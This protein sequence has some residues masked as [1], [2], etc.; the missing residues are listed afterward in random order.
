[1]G[2]SSLWRNIIVNVDS[3]KNAHWGMYPAGT[4]YVS[5]YI[6]SRGGA[7]PATLF[8]GLQAFLRE[9][10]TRPVTLDDIHEA[11]AVHG[12]MGVP[13]NRQNW[14]DLVN[15]H[16][17]RLPVEIEAVPEG[18]VVPT[19]N[20]LVQLVNTDPRYPWITNFIETALLRAVWYP[21]TVGTLS[22]T[23]KQH[24]KGFL[25]RTS[26]HPEL[27]RMYL[28]DYGA[29]GVSSLESAGLGGMAHLVNFDQ[30]D[31]VAGF[32]AARQWYNAK[33]PNG[34]ATFQEH[35]TV[36]AAGSDAEVESFRRLLQFPGVVVAGLL[37]DSFDHERAVKEILGK[38]LKDE[39]RDFP[40]LVAA[41]CDSGDPVMVP[42][43]TVEWLMDSFGYETNSKGFRVLPPNIRVV[44]GDGLTL[45]TFTAIYSTLQAHGLAADNVICGMGGGLLQRVNRDTINFGMKANAICVDGEWRDVAKTP[46]GSEMKRSKAGRLALQYAD[47]VYTTVRRET[48]PAEDNQLV[49]VFRD[50]RMLREW[51][52]SEL[53][54]RSERPTSENFS[55]GDPRPLAGVG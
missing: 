3:Y 5:S 42:V 55:S 44:Q 35:S 23:A 39:I 46:S 13:F 50:G 8:V 41:R 21:T 43:E 47:G 12:S 6:E 1:M 17:G 10:L 37:C 20:V 54:E 45:D 38:E 31:T 16:D 22:W 26:D 24:I 33:P 34:S 27:L 7:F 40:G 4:D 51:D 15:D 2:E 18:T 32:I 11:E 25:E 9:Y 49:P 30:T 29:R 19:G 28:H 48:I 14:I 52:F 36:I 53:I